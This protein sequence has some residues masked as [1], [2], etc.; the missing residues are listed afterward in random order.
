MYEFHP[1]DLVVCRTDCTDCGWDFEMGIRCH[2]TYKEYD[3]GLRSGSFPGSFRFFGGPF[4]A[5]V[6]FSPLVAC[7]WCNLV[8]PSHPVP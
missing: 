1:T 2:D 4:A 6:P 7:H 8:V 3:A 5:L